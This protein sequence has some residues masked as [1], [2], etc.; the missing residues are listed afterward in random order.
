MDVQ[1]RNRLL[2]R[3]PWVLFVLSGIFLAVFYYL[4]GSMPEKKSFIQICPDWRIEYFLNLPHWF[5]VFIL[6]LWGVI[7]ILGIDK[8]DALDDKYIFDDFGDGME[9]G[10]QG[11]GFFVS[12]YLLVFFFSLF[13]KGIFFG[14]AIVLV[15][16]LEL[17]ALVIL[18]F[19]TL[20]EDLSDL[21]MIMGAG[22]IF[23]C[24]CAWAAGLLIALRFGIVEGILAGIFLL[25]AFIISKAI[26]VLAAKI[27][28]CL[29][30][31]MSVS[32]VGRW[33]AGK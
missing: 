23:S 11:T 17:F 3:W 21:D 25:L 33:L 28:K 19:I 27:L 5:N 22:V 10:V 9:F 15:C 20:F 1:Y 32:L 12:I 24:G 31:L 13:D 16:Y 2:V 30:F 29:W 6:P 18:F 7:L 4:T 14:D 26:T 8:I